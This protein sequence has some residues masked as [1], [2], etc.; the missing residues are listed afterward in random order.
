MQAYVSAAAKISRLAVG[1]PTTSAEHHHLPAAA[2]AVAGRA[3]ATGMPLGTRGGMLVQHVFPLDAEYEFRV[4]R[5][6]AGSSG[7]RR[8]AATRQVEITLNGERVRAARTRRAARSARAEDSGRAADARRRDRPQAR[9]RTASTIC[10]PS[11]ADSAGVTNLAIIGPLNP[12][13]PGDTPSRR[14]IFVC[15]RRPTRR[16]GSRA[17]RA[18]T[19]LAALATRA[20]R[21][22]VAQSD[23]ALDTLLGSTSRAARCA[24][25]RPASSTRSRA[26]SSTRSSSSASS[27]SPRALPRGRGLPH[28]RSRARVAAVVLPLEQHSG[29]GAAR[30]WRRR[31]ACATGG[32]RAADAAHARRPA[33]RRAR[34]QLRRPVAAA[35]PARRRRARDEGVRRQ[36]AL[37]VPRRRSCCSRRSCAR[38]AASSICSTPTTRSS[39]SGWRGTTAS[40]T[41]A[42]AASA[43]SRSATSARRGLLGHGSILTVTSAATARRRSSAASGFSRTCSARRCRRRRPASRRT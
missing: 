34:R 39:T 17:V 18:A 31:A 26:C 28:Q 38:I 25:S 15:R 33:R 42:A 2:R 20:F 24:A 19:I 16:R 12:T 32:A 9:T 14:R 21:R 5:A 27:A 36:P 37:R 3:I 7:C 13:G 29:R 8:S 23:P 22:P 6:G 11:C 10:S 4:G 35:A 30:G 1:D 41:S 43:A 40:R